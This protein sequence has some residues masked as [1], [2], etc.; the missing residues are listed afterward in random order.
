MIE[1]VEEVFEELV[2]HCRQFAG[3]YPACQ[4][5]IVG[6]GDF[7]AAAGAEVEAAGEG[8]VQRADQTTSG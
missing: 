1:D 2:F 6:A 3:R 8:E 4:R 7:G 5:G